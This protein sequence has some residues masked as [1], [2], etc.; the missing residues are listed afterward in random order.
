MSKYGRTAA[1]LLA[2]LAIALA[3]LPAAAQD[4]VKVGVFPVSSSLPYFVALENG[5]FKEQNIEPEMIRLIGGPPNVAAMIGNQIDAVRGAGHDRG[6][7]R[8]HQEAGRRDVHLDQQPEPEVPDGA[9]RRPQGPRGEVARGSQGQEDHVG[10]RARQR[11][12]GE[13]GARR[14]RPQG[15]RLQHRSARHGPARQRHD[16]RHLRRRLH[17]RA[18]RLDHAQ[19]GR[20][21]DA[22]SRRDRQVRPGRSRTPMPSSAARR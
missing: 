9:V 10:A 19:D 15:G 20:R 22:R 21:H 17:A 2:G 8:Q 14:G 7:E 13:G 5:F 12:D 1:G 3:A 16:G 4:K 18:E 6:H 11:H